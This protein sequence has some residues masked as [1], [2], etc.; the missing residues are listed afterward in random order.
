MSIEEGEGI[1]TNNINNLFSSIIAENL[2][3]LEKGRNIQV[4]EAY[5]TPNCQD[6]KGNTHRYIIIK[7]LNKQTKQRKNTESCT[8]ENTVHI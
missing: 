8:R 1:Q 2:P 4:Q 3:N 5:R 7:I 6:Q